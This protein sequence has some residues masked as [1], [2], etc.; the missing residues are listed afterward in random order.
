MRQ[1]EAPALRIIARIVAW[2]LAASIAVVSVVPPNLRP[3]SGLPHGL[4]HVVIYW[5]GGVTF[6]LAYELMPVLFVTVLIIFSGAVELT[7]LF[8]PGRHARVSDFIV[9]AAA[10]IVGL[11]TVSLVAQMRE[12]M[13][14]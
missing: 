4:E 9:D 1:T 3:E 11:I 2:G 10:S 14:I 7:Q 5:A 8:V 6:A 13:R 12:R